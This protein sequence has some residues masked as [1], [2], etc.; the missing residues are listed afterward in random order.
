MTL[1]AGENL[2]T[3]PTWLV[4]PDDRIA[5][6]IS[7]AS[8]AVIASGF[9][10]KICLPARAAA[11]QIWRCIAVGVQIHTASID[12]SEI[13]SSAVSNAFAPCHLAASFSAAACDKS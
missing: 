13:I 10:Q 1:E 12:G 4:T 3:S 7:E 5:A 9:S 6:A 2:S 8:A 11:I